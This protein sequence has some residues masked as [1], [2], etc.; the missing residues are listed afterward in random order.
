MTIHSIHRAL[1]NLVA[2]EPQL[3]FI[4]AHQYRLQL[5]VLKNIHKQIIGLVQAGQAKPRDS[6]LNNKCWA[7]LFCCWTGRDWVSLHL[8]KV[9]SNGYNLKTN[10][11]RYFALLSFYRRKVSLQMVSIREKLNYD[12][13]QSGRESAPN[14]VGLLI[15]I[16]VKFSDS[17]V[18]PTLVA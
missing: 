3:G 7:L 4:R 1:N 5:H 8:G 9:F 17:G 11:I 2:L 16:H 14:F 15:S 18:L 12:F 13:S 10:R 6:R